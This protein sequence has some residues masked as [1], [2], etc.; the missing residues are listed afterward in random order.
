[1]SI[2]PGYKRNIRDQWLLLYY[3]RYINCVWVEDTKSD[4]IIARHFFLKLYNVSENILFS[5]NEKRNNNFFI[6]I[7]EWNE[8]QWNIIWWK[9][10]DDQFPTFYLL[11]T[12]TGK[13]LLITGHMHNNID[14]ITKIQLSRWKISSKEFYH[15]KQYEVQN[16]SLFLGIY[17]TCYWSL[18]LQ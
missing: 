6:C 18:R 3:L 14:F 7:I 2:F 17:F 8:F 9:V 1:M 13:T 4:K 16:S 11:F 12:S 5:V 10:D 15:S